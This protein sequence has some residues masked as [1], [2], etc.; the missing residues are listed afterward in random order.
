MFSI[1]KSKSSTLVINGVTISGDCSS[2]DI[3]NNKISVNGKEVSVAEAKVYNVVVNG[4][5]D[6]VQVA[7]CDRLTVNGST[8]NVKTVSGDVKCGDVAGNVSTVSGDVDC[9]SVKGN[10]STVSGD[11]T[12]K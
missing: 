7:C 3:S 5:I 8:N 10:V 4:N 6:T 2:L 1:L 11:V 9:N 12:E